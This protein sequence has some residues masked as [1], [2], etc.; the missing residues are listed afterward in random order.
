MAAKIT[1]LRTDPTTYGS[2]QRIVL[3]WYTITP[4]IQDSLG[5]NI[6]TQNRNQLPPLSTTGGTPLPYLTA[7]DLDSLDA[8]DSG[9]E[10]IVQTQ[11][12]GET[13]NSFRTRLLADHAAR[14]TAWIQ[15][16]RDQYAAAGNVAN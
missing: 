8:G 9:Y 11:T 4:K 2:Q 12:A 15:A 6:A 1:L 5:N 3:Y 14:Q 13:L 16:R 10:I 7:A